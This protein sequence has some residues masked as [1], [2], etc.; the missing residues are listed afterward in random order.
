MKSFDFLCMKYFDEFYH[1]GNTSLLLRIRLPLVKHL[2]IKMRSLKVVAAVTIPF[3]IQNVQQNSGLIFH[4]S[5][6]II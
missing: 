2:L 4:H 5:H 6:R 3:I 1:L